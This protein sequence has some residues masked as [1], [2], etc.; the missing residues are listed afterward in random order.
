M[1]IAGMFVES[2]EG[3]ETLDAASSLEKGFVSLMMMMMM[4]RRV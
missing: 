2:S 4:A 3:Y 1:F